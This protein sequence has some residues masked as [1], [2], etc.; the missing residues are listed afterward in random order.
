MDFTMND[1]I[2]GFV[3]IYQRLFERYRD[4]I[5]SYRLKPGQRV[6]SINEIQ[7][8]HSVSRETAKR[9]LTLLA[10]EGYIHQMRGRGTS[11]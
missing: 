11:L 1:Q 6:D 9:V 4:D 8:K 10:K 5:L 2:E 3:P 7:I